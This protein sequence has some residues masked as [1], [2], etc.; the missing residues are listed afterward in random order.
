MALVN[1]HVFLSA[2]ALTGNNTSSSKALQ[3]YDKNFGM[4]IVSTSQHA[5]TTVAAKI[6]HSNDNTN[7]HDLASFTNI[8][9]ASGGA[10]YVDITSNVLQYVRSVVTLSGATKQAT[11]SIALSYDGK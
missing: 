10:E 8:V 6:Q 9:G 5:D 2:V 4:T 1:K 7:W 11:V 3:L